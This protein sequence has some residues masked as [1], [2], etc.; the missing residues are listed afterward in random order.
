MHTIIITNLINGL[1]SQ[2]LDLKTFWGAV[3][4]EWT[5]AVYSLVGEY[6]P[7]SHACTGP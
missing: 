2:R 7:H 1:D 6:M 3:G 5:E 4:G